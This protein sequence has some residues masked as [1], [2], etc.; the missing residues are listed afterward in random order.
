MT[1]LR[2]ALAIGAS[3]FALAAASLLDVARMQP[4][5]VAASRGDRLNVASLA[6]DCSKNSI[7]AA[8]AGDVAAKQAMPPVTLVQVYQDTGKTT[9]V[10]IKLAQ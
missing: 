3:L 6:A 8:C 9:L 2:P 4:Q 10:K 7:I 5:Q 1:T